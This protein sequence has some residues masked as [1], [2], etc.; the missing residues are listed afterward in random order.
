MQPNDR[1]IS[2]SGIA[3]PCRTIQRFNFAQ[4]VSSVQHAP[5]QCHYLSH[6]RFLFGIVL[7]CDILLITGEISVGKC[8]S[9]QTALQKCGVEP[10]FYKVKQ[11]PSKPLFFGKKGGY[12]VSGLPGNPSEMLTCFYEYVVPCI[13]KLSEMNPVF[14]K[15]YSMTLNHNIHSRPGLT[16]FLK[17]K[18]NDT[19]VGLMN[20]DYKY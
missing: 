18:M 16:C 13:R 20:V 8:N 14:P 7:P 10:F 5:E 4:P 11:K 9:V 15:E 3:Q 1:F 12:L 6:S 2:F 17:G 19:S